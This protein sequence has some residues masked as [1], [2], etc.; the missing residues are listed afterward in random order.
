VFVLFTFLFRY[1]FVVV[2]DINHNGKKANNSIVLKEKSDASKSPETKV[3]RT[4]TANENTEKDY[5]E[6]VS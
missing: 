5:S 2:N 1:F 6:G 4:K 3:A